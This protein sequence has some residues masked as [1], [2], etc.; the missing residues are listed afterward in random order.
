MLHCPVTTG[1]A[2]PSCGTRTLR[3]RKPWW[4][5]WANLA[6]RHRV[7]YRRCATGCDWSG[8]A[9]HSPGRPRAPGVRAALRTHL[10][11]VT[12]GRSCPRCD[13]STVSVRRRR[14]SIALGHVTRR[15]CITSYDWSGFAAHAGRTRRPRGFALH[16]RPRLPRLAIGRACPRCDARTVR[17]RKP[18]WVRWLNPVLG[19]SV[20]YRRCAACYRWSGLAIVA[21]ADPTWNRDPQPAL[22]PAM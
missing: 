7:T 18:W 11:F 22:K 16:P 20:N 21:K 5:R 3:I 1:K 13:G 12:L 17:V 15:K 6:L 8:V 9:A 4:L 19:A 14:L 2:C 10:P